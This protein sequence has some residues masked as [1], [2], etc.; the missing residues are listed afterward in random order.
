MFYFLVALLLAAP[1]TSRRTHAWRVVDTSTDCALACTTPIDAD[2]DTDCINAALVIG[3][4]NEL[5]NA[6]ELPPGACYINERLEVLATEGFQLYGHGPHRTSLYWDSATDAD[7]VLYLGDV[8]DSLFRDFEIQP[9]ANRTIET[10]ITVDNCDNC[11]FPGETNGGNYSPSQNHFERINI[12]APSG[13]QEL[14]HGVVIE[15]H[16]HEGSDGVTVAAGNTLTSAAGGIAGADYTGSTLTIYG[17]ANAGDY[18][19]AGTPT[20]TVVTITTTFPSSLSGQSFALHP[21]EPLGANNEFHTFRDLRVFAYHGD[22]FRIEGGQHKT[23]LFDGV[24]CLSDTGFVEVSTCVR[25]DGCFVWTGGG[26]GFNDV[27][28]YNDSQGCQT[29]IRSANFEGSLKFIYHGANNGTY[30]GLIV[31]GSRWASNG[32]SGSETGTDRLVIDSGYSGSVVLIGNVIGEY[33]DPKPMAI[34][35]QG[36]G[37]SG[38]VMLGNAFFTTL[39][40][41]DVFT[42][43]RP[44]LFEANH[45]Y[46]SNSTGLPMK[47]PVML[48]SATPTVR[49]GIGGA[50]SST[51]LDV[52]NGTTTITD[53]LEG[54]DGQVLTLWGGGS[55]GRTVQDNANIALAADEDVTL[56]NNDILVLQ[57]VGGVWTEIGR[58]AS[59][60]SGTQVNATNLVA[61]TLTAAGPGNSLVITSD[62]YMILDAGEGEVEVEEHTF[63]DDSSSHSLSIGDSSTTWNVMGNADITAPYSLVGIVHGDWR[64]AA[65]LLASVVT[66]YSAGA[67][68]V[69]ESIRFEDEGANVY[70]MD[71]GT[72]ASTLNITANGDASDPYSLTCNVYGDLSVYDD[73]TVQGDIIGATVSST[74]GN[75]TLTSTSVETDY[76]ESKTAAPVDIEGVLFDADVLTQRAGTSSAFKRSPLVLD[77]AYVN[78]ATTGTTE[79]TLYTYTVPANVLTTNGWW[80][81][82]WSVWSTAANGNTKVPRVKAGGTEIAGASVSTNNN[83]LEILANIVR[84]GTDAQIWDS[85]T[86]AAGAS[87]NVRLPTAMTKDDGSSI[88]IDFTGHTATSAGDLTLRYVKIILYS[89]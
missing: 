7:P 35:L 49:L 30:S 77:V 2:R 76:I 70:A 68:V 54:Y 47:I 72:A 60:W 6:V 67:G 48:S 64:V 32:L 51:L 24:T 18:T 3:V 59:V 74:G 62:N 31:I 44:A 33:T 14:V 84:T 15:D 21:T 19:I 17:G 73:L 55:G 4:T 13:L 43:Y 28:F 63:S 57:Q 29:D 82:T 80:I 56:A 9:A 87:S 65:S 58:A 41:D 71:V 12:G 38:S 11:A 53:F 46:S 36:G 1:D 83:K 26:G 89:E 42:V 78:V 75:V 39:G 34:R 66:E 85:T 10:A 5:Y 22:A 69:I 20:S 81:E 88:A 8:R 50:G 45:N 86:W 61:E 16:V 23:I 79:E 25:S 40:A 27:D 52:D 37:V